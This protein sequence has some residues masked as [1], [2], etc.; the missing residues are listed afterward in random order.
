MRPNLPIVSLAGTYGGKLMG[1]LSNLEMNAFSYSG[2]IASSGLGD[3]VVGG[4]GGKRT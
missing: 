1:S 3:G 2:V 4:G